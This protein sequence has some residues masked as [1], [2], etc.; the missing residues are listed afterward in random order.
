MPSL[1]KNHC[2]LLAVLCEFRCRLMFDCHLLYI[3]SV[4]VLL[5]QWDAW[6]Y[7]WGT[8][9]L[10]SSIF[11]PAVLKSTSYS[12]A[13]FVAFTTSDF[14]SSFCCG[15]CVSAPPEPID[16]PHW[17]MLFLLWHTGYQSLAL[18]PGPTPSLTLRLLLNFWGASISMSP[19]RQSRC[20]I[21]KRLQRADFSGL[22]N[23]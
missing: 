21:N 16:C 7:E 14:P 2:S 3:S 8:C 4:H 1:L 5:N 11:C 22:N 12:F 19:A 23:L 20:C 9:L 6:R 18:W 17:L 15:S 10:P 13:F